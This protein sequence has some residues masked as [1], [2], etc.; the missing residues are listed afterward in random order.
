MHMFTTDTIP[1]NFELVDTHGVIAYLYS[2]QIQY[3]N[4]IQRAMG[5]KDPGFADGLAEF[6]KFAS[7]FGH[8][9]VFGIRVS[10]SIGI[11]GTSAHMYIT[12]H[13]TLATIREKGAGS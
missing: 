4:V 1:P 9:A 10:S 8:N 5:S 11:S 12:H 6:E 2:F 7:S 13:A 3:K